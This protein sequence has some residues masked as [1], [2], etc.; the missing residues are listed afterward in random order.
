LA[1]VIARVTP[2]APFITVWRDERLVGVVT[3]EA[4]K[5]RLESVAH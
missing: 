2:L 5:R 3:S 4:L 1:Q